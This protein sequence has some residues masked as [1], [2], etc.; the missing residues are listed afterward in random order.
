M[1]N[2][3]KGAVSFDVDGATQSLA[4]TTNAMVRYQDAMG[5]TLLTGLNALQNDP[6]DIR[7]VRGIMWA[8]LVGDFSQDEAGDIMDVVGI[9]Q[10]VQLLAEAATIA[11]PEADA[12]LGNAQPAMKS[13]KAKT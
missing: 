5:E 13:R 1:T 4:F 9:M 3:K 8:G 11:F 6:T 10:S 7:R 2:S 12:D